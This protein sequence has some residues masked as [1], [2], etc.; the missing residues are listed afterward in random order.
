MSKCNKC[1]CDINDGASESFSC[2]KCYGAYLVFEAIAQSRRGAYL[3]EVA[4]NNGKELGEKATKDREFADAQASTAVSKYQAIHKV[5]WDDHLLSI[6][7]DLE[8]KLSAE[9]HCATFAPMMLKDK[10]REKKLADGYSA[11]PSYKPAYAKQV[12]Q[13]LAYVLD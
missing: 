9:A 5:R 8:N 7:F 6:G 2:P 12:T 11:T 1:G 13:Q 10:L 3:H 4:S